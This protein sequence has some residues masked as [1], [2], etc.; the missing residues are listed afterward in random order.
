LEP[1]PTEKERRK[2]DSVAVDR[3]PKGNWQGKSRLPQE[4]WGTNLPPSCQEL[5]EEERLT[6]RRP[7]PSHPCG[8]IRTRRPPRSRCRPRPPTTPSPQR[9]PW[10]RT[11]FSRLYSGAIGLASPEVAARR[12]GMG[13]GRAALRGDGPRFADGKPADGRVVRRRQEQ[14]SELAAG[15][16]SASGGGSGDWVPGLGGRLGAAVNRN[17]SG[18]WAR[19]RCC[20]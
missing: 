10:S 5:V 11:S 8:I 17:P 15:I 7:A 18:C 1:R 14:K 19:R 3:D 16:G 20:C 6:T 13:A 4:K 9:S 2:C 12:G